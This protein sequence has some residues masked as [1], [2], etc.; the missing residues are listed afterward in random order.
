MSRVDDAAFER[1]V[2]VPPRGIGTRTL[3]ELRTIAREE[4]I[5]LWE[6][7]R[8]TIDF[9]RLGMRS[10]TALT[11]FVALIERMAASI[12]INEIGDSLERV[13]TLSGLL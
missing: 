9:G 5:S 6:A 7:S 10:L 12:S 8:K 13:I 3:E 4:E 11:K 2:N 1:I